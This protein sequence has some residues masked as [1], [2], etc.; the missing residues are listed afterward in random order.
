[1][2]QDFGLI[3]LNHCILIEDISDDPTCDKE[4]HSY[5]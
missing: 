3:A 4:Q 5:G 2:L 1:M